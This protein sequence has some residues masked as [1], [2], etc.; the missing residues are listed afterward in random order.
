MH[1]DQITALTRKSNDFISNHGIECCIG[2][3]AN[4]KNLILWTQFNA[5][6]KATGIANELIDSTMSA[7]RETA[8][9]LSLGLV[10]PALFSLRAQI[11]LVLTWIY[12]KDHPVE[13]RRVNET[14]E[15][16]KLKTEVFKYLNELYPGFSSRFN[17]LKQTASRKEDDPYRLLSA[18]IHAQS[19]A[20]IPVVVSL[21]DT[22][23]SLV[24]AREC[25][26]MQFEV[27]EYLSDILAAAFLED[28]VKIAP[29]IIESI[30]NRLKTDAQ[31]AT[32]YAGI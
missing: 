5:N 22:I 6:H 10:R 8:A 1:K 14:G 15:G 3:E 23:A 21:S 18:H 30:S 17:I 13:W 24:I 20:V 9:C 31:R 26:K 16:F 32:L 25:M 28:H 27:T 4:A 7:I 2:I 29:E 19:T 11:D 12:F